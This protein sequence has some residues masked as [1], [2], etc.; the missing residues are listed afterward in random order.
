[1]LQAT[2]H[3]WPEDPGKLNT[4]FQTKLDSRNARYRY[5]DTKRKFSFRL[6]SFQTKRTKI[7]PDKNGKKSSFPYLALV[8]VIRG[9]IEACLKERAI[10]GN[11]LDRKPSARREKGR[12]V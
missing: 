6:D 10:G 11:G 9:P 7:C 1:M 12:A 3:W 5:P 8:G 2:F 4:D